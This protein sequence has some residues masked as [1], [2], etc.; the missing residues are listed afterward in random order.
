MLYTEKNILMIKR[1][2]TSLKNRVVKGSII[3][4]LLVGV[5]A[6]I[7]SFTDDARNFAIIKNLD[8][9]YSLFRELNSYYVDKTDPEKLIKTS[10]DKMLESLDP[11]TTYIPESELD[12][13][14]FMTTGE[15]GGIGSL[16]SKNGDYIV[17]AEPYDGFPAQKAGLKAGD[18]ILE[19]DGKSMKTKTSSDVSNNLKGPEGTKF[20]IKVERF[21][22]KKPLDFNITR[23]KISINP[24]SYFGMIDGETGI[25]LLK[26]FTQNCSEEVQKAFLDLRDKQHAKRI[27]LDLRGNPGGLLEEAIR[28]VNF[29]VPRGQEIV[30]T[31]GNVKQWD[32]VYKGT[33]APID[34]VLPLAVLISRGSASASEI[35]AGA[36]QDLDRAVIIGQRSFGKGLVQTT[37]NLSYNAKLKVTTAKYYIPSGRCI[38]ALD[39]TH[40]NEDGSVGE[41][42]DSL[43]SKFSTKKGRTVFDGGGVSPDVK[44][45]QEKFANILYALVTQSVIFDFATQYYYQH[46]TVAQPLQYSVD[47]ETFNKF[48]EFALAKPDLKYVSVTQS[49]LKDL[50]KTAT[51]EGYFD[52]AKPEFEA[53]QKSLELDKSK[54]LVRARKQISLLLSDEILKRYYFQK[55]AI[56]NSILTDEDI[57]TARILLADKAKYTGVLDGSVLSH[58]GDKKSSIGVI[59]DND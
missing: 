4:A 56:V 17:I 6:G 8:I 5:G 50:I 7:Y 34:T 44:V 54:D 13:F 42:A 18:K 48:V 31:R 12:D 24:V 43:I 39:Y 2:K 46:P 45:E 20:T 57:K 35:V 28:M 25:I 1:L 11:Y 37:R 10:M 49:K 14:K 41:I 21:G 58:A 32:K 16:I 15:Y 27:I 22:A 19:I 9:Y 30:S 52:V 38:Q 53:L 29:F 59:E 55:G 47:D 40:R 51:K 26:S 23:E 3:L 33:E 36:L